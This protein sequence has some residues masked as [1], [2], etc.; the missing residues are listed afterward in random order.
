MPWKWRT[1]CRQIEWN[2][3]DGQSQFVLELGISLSS[4]HK[5]VSL[6]HPGV[7]QSLS[8]PATCSTFPTQKPAVGIRRTKCPDVCLHVSLV[9]WK[10]WHYVDGDRIAKLAVGSLGQN[11]KTRKIF[12]FSFFWLFLYSALSRLNTNVFL[13]VSHKSVNFCE[14]SFLI[15]PTVV[16][17]WQ[18]SLFFWL[19][20]DSLTLFICL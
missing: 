12:M 19:V 3:A 13:F 16:H 2:T 4:K 20:P 17:F 14:P 15:W 11:V 1:L 5:T 6:W 10:C 7:L 8:L 9:T 18:F